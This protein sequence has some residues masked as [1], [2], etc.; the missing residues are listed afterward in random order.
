MLVYYII[1]EFKIRMKMKQYKK[2]IQ[3]VIDTGEVRTDRTGVG[4]ISI[5][6]YQSKYDLSEGFPIVTIKKTVWK[7]VVAELIW[8]LEG[9]TDERRLAELTFQKPRNELTEKNTIWTANAN[10]QGVKLGYRNDDEVKELGPVYGYNFRNFNGF[11]QLKW[12]VDEIK[13][14]PNSRR[15]I[16]SCWNANRINE[17]ALPPCHTLFHFYVSEG[18]LSCQLYQR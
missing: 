8:F 7:P 17:M 3:D 1:K 13:T 6:G 16:L 9:S 2:L 11:D 5:F 4:T 18:K 12:L 14:N 15:L 10:E